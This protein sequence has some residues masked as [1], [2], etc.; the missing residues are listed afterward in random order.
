[1]LLILCDNVVEAHA[2]QL[3]NVK[4]VAIEALEDVDERVIRKEETPRL[5]PLDTSRSSCVSIE[6]L[7]LL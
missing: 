2:G 6:K 3:Q 4:R 5:K 7:Q 1:M